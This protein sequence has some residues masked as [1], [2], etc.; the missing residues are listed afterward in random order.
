[1]IDLHNHLLGE[2]ELDGSLEGALALCEQAQRDGV[3]QIVV[4]LRIAA[5]REDQ[6][7]QTRAYVRRLAELRAK[8]AAPLKLNRGYEWPFSAE[9]P[10]RLRRF[11]EA[12]TIHESQYL[13]LSL[14][15]LQPPE[16]YE[17][18][19]PALLRDGYV[20]II[21][22]PECSRALRRE[23][24]ILARLIKL[25]ALVQMDALSILGGYGAE[26]ERFAR[27]L[28]EQGQV[29]FLATRAGQAA[30][31][32]VSLKAACERASRIIGRKAACRLVE[33]NP[34]A[35]LGNTAIAGTSAS[36]RRLPMLK[37]ALNSWG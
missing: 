27:W 20:P 11:T 12:P 5:K 16:G 3:K 37:A 14:P 25:G 17:E 30:R 31:S 22:H 28:L 4:T 23:A 7:A 10:A 29:H 34:H 18:V 6:E 26:V 8:L 15:S 21:T 19:F 13:L 2:N 24:S 32:G 1:M 36:G 9:L 33:D 35:V